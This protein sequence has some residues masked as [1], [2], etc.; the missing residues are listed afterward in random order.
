[1]AKDCEFFSPPVFD[2]H[3]EGDPVGI[4]PRVRK[5]KCLGDNFLDHV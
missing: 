3:L 5:L 2:P 1:M 4:L